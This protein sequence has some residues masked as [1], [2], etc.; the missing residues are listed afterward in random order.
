MRQQLVPYLSSDEG[1]FCLEGWCQQLYIIPLGSSELQQGLRKSNNSFSHELLK[2][3]RD[4]APPS[5][6]A[7][8]GGTATC[9][10]TL[11]VLDRDRLCKPFKEPR[12]LFTSWRNRFLE[13]DSCAGIFKQSMGARNR[14]EIGL[15]YRPARLHSLAVLVPWNRFMGSLQVLKFGL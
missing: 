15:S 1:K 10:S 7:N 4:T 2:N 14:V 6:S 12:N 13:I 3:P 9:L 11:L 5:P 8:T